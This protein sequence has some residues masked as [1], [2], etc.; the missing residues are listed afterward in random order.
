MRHPLEQ[1]GLKRLIQ[2]AEMYQALLD[3]GRQVLPAT[4]SE[5]LVA[6]SLEGQKLICVVDHP[7]WASKLRFFERDLLHIFDQ[8]LPHLKLN[9]TQFRISQTPSEIAAPKRAANRP[10]PE[11]A[12]EM[13][14]LSKT[15]PPKL[16]QTLLKLSQRAEHK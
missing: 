1:Q 6:I 7:N 14:K 13:Q 16:A 11:A 4:L 15:L 9:Q 12:I 5:H 2:Q 8:N 10:P 3:L